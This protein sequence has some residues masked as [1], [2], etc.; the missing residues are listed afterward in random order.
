MVVELEVLLVVP[1]LNWDNFINF[2]SET[3]KSTSNS[4]AFLLVETTHTHTNEEKCVLLP[5]FLNIH[6]EIK[7]KDHFCYLSIGSIVPKVVFDFEFKIKSLRNFA[8]IV[9]K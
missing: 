7:L 3:I 9:I 8:V 6:F 4:Y 5:Y 1:A 2:K